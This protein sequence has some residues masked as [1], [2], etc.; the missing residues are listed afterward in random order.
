MSGARSEVEPSSCLLKLVRHGSFIVDFFFYVHAYL[1][2]SDF[3]ASN[4]R[5]KDM[6]A[7]S[8]GLDSLPDTFLCRGA[9]S[10]LCPRSCPSNLLL[11]LFDCSFVLN[12]CRQNSFDVIGGLNRSAKS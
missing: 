11:T 8:L 6:P 9:F 10:L 4:S 1:M 2:A 12:S 5:W 7:D 3:G